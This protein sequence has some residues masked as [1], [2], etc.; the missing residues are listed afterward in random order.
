[1]YYHVKTCGCNILLF[2]TE[3]V[4]HKA[5]VPVQT[6]L[7]QVGKIAPTKSSE[8]DVAQLSKD[9]DVVLE[10]WQKSWESTTSHGSIASNIKWL[11]E[12]QEHGLYHPVKQYKTRA[13]DYI[14]RKVFKDCMKFNPPPVPTTM[15]GTIPNMHA[16]FTT[17]VFFLATRWCDACQNYMP[18][19]DLSQPKGLFPDT[20][21]VWKY[22]Q[23]GM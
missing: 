9:E 3:K 11:K 13:G 19:Q 14:E 6:T 1:M 5:A 17:P 22:R 10:G 21:W 15:M 18:Q 2:I 20:T 23:T 4:L 7:T 12:S 8:K 16:F